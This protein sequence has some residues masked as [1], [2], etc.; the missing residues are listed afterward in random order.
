M[1]DQG[2]ETEVAQERRRRDDNSL[3]GMKLNLRIPEDVQARLTAEGREA[4]WVNDTGNRIRDLTE[5]DDYDK[6]AGV[7]PVQVLVDR[8]RGIYVPAYLLSKPKAFLA[9]DRAKRDSRRRETEAAMLKGRVP[10]GDGG[11]SAPVRGVDGAQA[12]VVGGSNVERGN[13]IIE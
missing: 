11:A 5:R 10:T 8:Q 3:S 2:R 6:V 7:E 13:Q 4:R 1:N 12:Y 9:E